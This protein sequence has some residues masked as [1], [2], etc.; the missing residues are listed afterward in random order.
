[1]AP[2]SGSSPDS[3]QSLDYSADEAAL[4]EAS[5][6]LDA[7]EAALARLE[8]GSFERCEVCGDRIGPERLRADP[9]LTRCARHQQA[10]DCDEGSGSVTVEDRPGDAA[11][12]PAAG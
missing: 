10:G 5:A 1:M 7:V 2:D 12:D 6:E 8:D 11:D 9:L 4:A 3:P